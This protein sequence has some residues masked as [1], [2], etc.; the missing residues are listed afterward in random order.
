M[1]KAN[2]IGRRGL[3]RG[4]RHA[5]GPLGRLLA[6]F[7]FHGHGH[8]E[9]APGN[10]PAYAT[11]DG[12]RAVW[13]A[14]GALGV[15]AVLQIIIVALSGSVALLADTVHNV[16]DLLNS[17]PLLIAFYLARRPATRRYTYG[18]GR[19][20][21]VAG[22]VIVLSILFSAG[23]IFWESFQKLLDPRPIQEVWWVAAA[24]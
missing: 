9:Q 1:E 12:I 19:A 15:T 3:G 10:D 16:G 23:Y 5:G 20:E 6:I 11:Q 2:G 14:I 24:A 21:D 4:H 13:I 7:H 17:V 8:D 18:Y 22:V